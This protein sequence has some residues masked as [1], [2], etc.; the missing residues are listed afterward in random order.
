MSSAWL[1]PV[2]SCAALM[3]YQ[4]YIEA[5]DRITI[6]RTDECLEIY[7]STAMASKQKDS[8]PSLYW[9]A[10]LCVLHQLAADTTF[11]FDEC[12]SKDA[13]A[14][15]DLSDFPAVFERLNNRPETPVTVNQILI[16]RDFPQVDN[17]SLV[18]LQR[19][20]DLPLQIALSFTNSQIELT[21]HRQPAA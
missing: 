3:I 20:A 17:T 21:L 2:M 19:L 14:G 15:V 11:H 13:I 4:A 16:T 5:N 7:F 8:I 6:I 1:H 9:H 12:H 18:P 10:L